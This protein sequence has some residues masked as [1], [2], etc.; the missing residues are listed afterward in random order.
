MARV[1]EA[2]ADFPKDSG[3]ACSSLDYIGIAL[4]IA[5]FGKSDD[6][7]Q[8]DLISADWDIRD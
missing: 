5:E 3:G 1:G 4:S 6:I 2:K 7:R 8:W